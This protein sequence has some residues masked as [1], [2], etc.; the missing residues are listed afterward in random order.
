MT[1][2]QLAVLLVAFLVAQPAHIARAWGDEGHQVVAA[3]A[4]ARLDPPVKKKVDDLL[5]A[6]RDRLTAADFVSRS[7]WADKWRDSDRNSTKVRYN[8]TH[9]WHFV[10]LEIDHPDLD[11]ACFRHPSLPAGIAASAGPARD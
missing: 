6:D 3:I 9:N 1:L 11:D 7:T 8:A 2:R 4:Y 5:A 10:D